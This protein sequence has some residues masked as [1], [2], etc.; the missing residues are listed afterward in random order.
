[1]QALSTA[2]QPLLARVAKQWDAGRSEDGQVYRKASPLRFW[3][4]VGGLRTYASSV[5][6][7]IL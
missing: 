3:E 1:V 5:W 6:P 4:V 7:R 2:Q